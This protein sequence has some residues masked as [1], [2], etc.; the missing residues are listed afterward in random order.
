MRIGYHHGLES[1]FA[2]LFATLQAPGCVVGW[3]LKY[4]PRQLRDLVASV[5]GSEVPKYLEVRP[6]PYTWEGVAEKL[7]LPWQEDEATIE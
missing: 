6:E 2:L 7:C 3:M 4:W 1:F 5:D